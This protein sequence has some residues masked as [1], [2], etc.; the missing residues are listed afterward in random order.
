MP[1]RQHAFTVILNVLPV[2]MND[3][4]HQGC[5]VSRIAKESDLTLKVS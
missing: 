1:M 4:G 3:G 5:E 2:R